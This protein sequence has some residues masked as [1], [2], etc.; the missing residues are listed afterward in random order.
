M[1]KYSSKRYICGASVIF[2]S[3]MLCFAMLIPAQVSAASMD[4]KAFN[5]EMKVRKRF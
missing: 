2:I 4:T 5:V 1:L 3:L